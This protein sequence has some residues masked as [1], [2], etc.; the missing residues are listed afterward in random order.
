VTD[1]DLDAVT[2]ARLRVRLP[3]ET[4]RYRFIELL[5]DKDF[6]VFYPGAF[7]GEQA[8]DRFDHMLAVCE[9]L[10]FGKQPRPKRKRL[11]AI[12][13]NGH[14]I[15]QR[16]VS[17][18][19]GPGGVAQLVHRFNAPLAAGDAGQACGWCPFRQHSPQV[20]AVSGVP[21]V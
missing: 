13:R 16:G 20:M 4:D 15:G 7:T 6:M 12:E 3:R 17:P 19:F 10:P 11:G 1:P 2:T 14:L 9:I 21:L 8:S 18:L 5:C